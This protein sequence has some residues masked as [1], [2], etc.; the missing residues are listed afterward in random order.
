MST[1][2]TSIDP[3]L[4]QSAKE[5]FMKYGFL[6]AELKTICEKAGVTTGAVYKRYKGKEELFRAVVQDTV[7][8]LDEFID[9]RTDVDFSEM[10]DEEVRSTW[11]MNEEYMLAMF[12]MLWNLRDDFVLL[13]EKSGGTVYENYGHDFAHRMTH[14]YMQYYGEAKKRGLTTTDI[15]EREMHVLCTSFWTAVYEPFVHSMNWDEVKE[16]CRVICRF[17]NWFDAIS[18]Q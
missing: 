13:L 8:T 16:H 4:L 7:D 14:A 10:T 11:I 3:K 6:K 1:R 9:A 12:K 2:D 15:S 18:I 5:E 17:F